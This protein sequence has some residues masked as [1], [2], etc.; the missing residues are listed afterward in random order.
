M[1]ELSLFTGGGGGVLATHFLLGWRT[2]GYVEN[3]KYAQ[4]ILAARI[5]DGH[6]DEAP[7]FGDIRLFND[8]WARSYRGLVDCV[9]GGFPCQP[10]SVAGLQKGADDERNLW[11]EM[12]RTIRLVRP[13]HVYAENVA[14]IAA[15]GYL[16]TV[17]GDLAALGYVGRHGVL[18]AAAA[19]AKHLR[20]RLWIWATLEGVPDSERGGLRE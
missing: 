16:S 10:H 15:N 1:N 17:V 20:K 7:I 18:S 8:Q 2:V 3:E 13:Q 9:T 5:R 11:P 4:Q 19:G 14:G 6:L 12:V